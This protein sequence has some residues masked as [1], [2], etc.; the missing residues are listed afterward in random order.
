MQNVH[1]I[2]VLDLHFHMNP[3]ERMERAR[4]PKVTDMRNVVETEEKE[5]E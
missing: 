2:P 3:E 1:K 5:N 4:P